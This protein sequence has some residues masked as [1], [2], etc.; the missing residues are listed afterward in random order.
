MISTNENNTATIGSNTTQP[1]LMVLDQY[2]YDRAKEAHERCAKYLNDLLQDY[3]KI[4][5]GE[6]TVEDFEAF[7]SGSRSTV[8]K[9]FTDLIKS[10]CEHIFPESIR[11][12]HEKAYRKGSGDFF[13]VLEIRLS[14]LG[15]FYNAV[16]FN[17][18][19]IRFVES[20]AVFD[21][22]DA[23]MLLRTRF[24]ID[25]SLPRFQEIL[26]EFNKLSQQYESFRT[27]LSDNINL[28]GIDP[29]KGSIM[30][31]NGALIELDP[32]NE[33]EM[34]LN[35]QKLQGHVIRG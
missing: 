22:S 7:R 23:E 19:L 17:I 11:H 1:H 16:G 25:I 28:Y 20:K 24:S 4:V 14:G 13:T 31:Q 26:F 10:K 9:R 18:G 29:Y 15:R 32:M 33:T 35:W 34:K 3:Q 27:F 5:G 21:E 6:L 2:G 30:G 12:E 8:Y